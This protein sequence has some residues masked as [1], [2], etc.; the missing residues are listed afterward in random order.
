[1]SLVEGIKGGLKSGGVGFVACCVVAPQIALSYAALKGARGFAESCS[2][3]CQASA[4]PVSKH[5]HDE[6]ATG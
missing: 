5:N 6:I 3:E 2:G 4:Q 1:M